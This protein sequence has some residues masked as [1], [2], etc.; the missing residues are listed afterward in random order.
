MKM[1]LR[2]SISCYG[3]LED[4]GT[5]VL[6]SIVRSSTYLINGNNLK[7]L[8]GVTCWLSLTNMMTSAPRMELL[9]RSRKVPGGLLCR[10]LWPSNPVVDSPQITGY[11]LQP[12]Y[13]VLCKSEQHRPPSSTRH[14]DDGLG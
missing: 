9:M 13:P 1:A 6:Y 10:S 2:G 5:R 4:D 3:V 12:Q 11:I 14:L 8:L 7:R